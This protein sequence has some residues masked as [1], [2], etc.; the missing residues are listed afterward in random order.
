MLRPLLPSVAQTPISPSESARTC[1]YCGTPTSCWSHDG[2]CV[3]CN[4]VLHLDRPRIDA[5]AVI[6]WIPEL[7]QAALNRI[8]RELHCQ[9]HKSQTG[10]SARPGPHYVSRALSERVGAASKILG[11]SCAS[12]LG[13]ALALLTPASYA[14]RYRL[15]AGV[16]I[17]PAGQF[18]V[19]DEDIYPD[20]LEHW[21]NDGVSNGVT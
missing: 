21:C 10:F 9:L 8:M 16:R 20:I 15:L 2:A 11:T 19:D 1:A 3:H 12:E 5:E 6:G 17:L 14:D 4:L 13:Q 7:S 18:F